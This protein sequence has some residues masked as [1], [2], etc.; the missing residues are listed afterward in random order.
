MQTL[1]PSV[2]SQTSGRLS[3]INS[4]KELWE[5]LERLYQAKGISNR[6]YLKEQFHTLRME[7]GAKISDHLSV[8]NGIVSE[9]ESI[10][11][12]IEDEDKALSKRE[13]KGY[14]SHIGKIAKCQ[15]FSRLYKEI[16]SLVSNCTN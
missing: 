10:G 6:L 8:L 13:E 9:L 2:I 4:F 7:E 15:G 3:V 11:V 14:E 5:K 1:I 16:K 12:E